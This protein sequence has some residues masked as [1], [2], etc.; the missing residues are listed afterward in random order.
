[1]VSSS[2]PPADLCGRDDRPSKVEARVA[3]GPPLSAGDLG[4]IELTLNLRHPKWDTRVGGIRVLSPEPLLIRR[5]QWRRICSEAEEA[6]RELMVLERGI[7]CDEELKRLIGL[8]R[9]LREV[10]NGREPGSGPRT[11]RYDFHPTQT[12]WVISEV[13]S[14][15]PGGLLEASVLPR[16]Y[17]RYSGAVSAAPPDPLERW[18]DAMEAH[19]GGGTAVLLSAPGYLEDE[20]VVRSLARVLSGRGFSARL[21]QHPSALQWAGGGASLRGEPSR[22]VDLVVRF[23]QAEWLARLP[24][25][26]GWKRLFRDSGRIIVTNP[27]LAVVS[28]SKRLGLCLSRIPDPVTDRIPEVV[29]DQLW[30]GARSFDRLLP[31]SREPAEIAGLP[32]E[33][34]VLKAAYSNTGDEVHLGTHCG[35]REWSRLL[36]RARDEPCQW[37]AQR[38]FETV[39]LPSREGPV[40]PCVGVFVIDG[41]AAG[42]YVRLSRGEVTDG[43]SLEAPLFLMEEPESR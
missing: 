23:Y 4:E 8:P 13:N 31:E 14:D 38:R 18:A 36:G 28:E 21:I 15:V 2:G 22:R 42:A 6:S 29:T 3:L 10:V 30:T 24:G 16:L 35:A 27:A 39:S 26:T 1:M 11:L 7:A 19:V 40:R 34:W 43:Y 33:E 20:Q 41:R 5:D 32:K 37:V 9:S 12:G 25:R 17:R